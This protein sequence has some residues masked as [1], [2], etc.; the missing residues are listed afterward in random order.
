R[1]RQKVAAQ[2]IAD[3][4]ASKTLSKA[5]AAVEHVVAMWAERVGLTVK[6]ASNIH[7]AT[8]HAQIRDRLAGMKNGRMG[9]LEKNAADPV[10]A[11]AIL[12]APSFLSGL[13][14][15]ELGLV[16]HKVEQHVSP[17]I[18]GARAATLKALEQ[19]K[20]GW[21]RAQDAIGKRGGLVKG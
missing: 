10:I 19:A 11:S 18:A 20:A 21:R 13:S 8:V 2:A 6:T 1:Q 5:S 3:F 4:E 17:E 16:K 12:T 14:D 9:F 7:E 15:V